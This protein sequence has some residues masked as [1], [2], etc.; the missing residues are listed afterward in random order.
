[1]SSPTTRTAL[2][3]S[4]SFKRADVAREFYIPVELYLSPKAASGLPKVSI[5]ILSSSD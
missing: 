1:M 3:R 5:V 4:T 2:S